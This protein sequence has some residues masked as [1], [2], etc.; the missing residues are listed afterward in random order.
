MLSLYSS[1]V[2]PTGIQL[3]LLQIIPTHRLGI[4]GAAYIKYHQHMGFFGYYLVW[5]YCISS[6]ALASR[7]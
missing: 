2:P 4:V 3:P 1:S 6:S 5:S 7:Q